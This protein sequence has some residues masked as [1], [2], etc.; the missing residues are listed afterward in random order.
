VLGAV[1]DETSTLHLVGLSLTVA[2]ANL[3][4]LNERTRQLRTA[5]TDAQIQ[6]VACDAQHWEGLRTTAPLGYDLLRYLFE[7]DTPTLTR[8][9]PASSAALQGG[10]GVPILYG[11]RAEGSGALRCRV[12][13]GSRPNALVPSSL[14]PPSPSRGAGGV[15]ANSAP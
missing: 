10:Q 1:T 8:L 14:Q 5:C 9:L 15:A 7:T 2:G 11:V 13:P 12:F 3:R 4:E 6:I